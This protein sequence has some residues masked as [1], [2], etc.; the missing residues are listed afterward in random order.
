MKRRNSTKKYWAFIL[1]LTLVAHIFVLT[2]QSG[3]AY[4]DTKPADTNVLE[5]VKDGAKPG[6]GQT[7]LPDLK[8][9]DPTNLPQ[10]KSL[11]KMGEKPIQL[12]VNS[13]EGFSVLDTGSVTTQWH[14]NTINARVV[15]EDSKWTTGTI[16]QDIYVAPDTILVI[17]GDVQLVGDLYNYGVV[18]LDG[19]LSAEYIYAN[20]YYVGVGT[21]IYNGDF[22]L[23]DE[24]ADGGIIDLLFISDITSM[25]I[26]IYSGNEVDR[27]GYLP[28][29]QGAV[30]PILDLTLEDSPV[31]L[32]EN[33]S[34]TL[35]DYYVGTKNQ[36]KFTMIDY[37]G[38]TFT[39][40]QD[41][42]FA[43]YIPPTLNVLA[44][45]TRFDTARQ[46]SS[47]SYASATTA[48]LVKAT[49]FPDALAAGPLAYALQAPILL[50]A[51]DSLN[52]VTRQE[53]IRL[54]V[55]KVIILG[56]TLV[57]NSSVEMTLRE[58]YEVERIAGDTRYTTAMLA[59]NRL[60][61]QVG[62]P[63]T[64]V[65]TSGTSYADA[66]SAGSYAAVNHFPLILTNG[67]NV[68]QHDLDF[69]AANGVTSVLLMGG[70][71]IISTAV[72]NL[73][74]N[75]GLTVTRVY[76]ASRYDTSAAMA[77]KYFPKA[78]HAIAAN[79]GTF[80]DALSAIP[81]AAQLNAPI[82][83]VRKDYVDASIRTYLES[84]YVHTINVI[85]GDQVVS[86]AARTM[87]LTAIQ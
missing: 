76:G 62:A 46:V 53:L 57:I 17:Q 65:M 85:G 50:T 44:G 6:Q 20:D 2:V 37:F 82:L 11:N 75:R 43:P 52:E 27:K 86:P 8:K 47:A 29:V 35:N 78:T 45:L 48:I 30:L 83:L 15:T 18:V 69:I 4:A 32:Y 73:L 66:L 68:L 19:Y 12:D 16:T 22:I 9:L 87:L 24:F 80:A 39:Y 28:L 74:K 21:S 54:G 59:A 36:I 55:Q 70:P 7:G 56:G 3:T 64:I 60:K 84:T 13:L 33:G 72:E 31:S 41:L 49:D 40:Y 23:Y 14:E 42:V 34:Y 1:T 79:G 71:T 61:D 10:S 81:F 25:P 51:T 38:Q 67:T 77:T 26:A 5:A 63:A 58:T